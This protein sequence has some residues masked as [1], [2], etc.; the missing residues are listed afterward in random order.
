VK[1]KLFDEE[2]EEQI[3]MEIFVELFG[4]DA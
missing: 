3:V 4:V 1:E 2:S